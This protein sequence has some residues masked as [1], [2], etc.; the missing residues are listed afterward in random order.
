[1]HLL[2]GYHNKHKCG[3]TRRQTH[4][5]HLN[6]GSPETGGYGSYSSGGYSSLDSG[7]YG[8]YSSGSYGSLDSGSYGSYSSGSY[9]SLDSGSYGSAGSGGDG[10]YGSYGPDG[11]PV[12]FLLF[13]HASRARFV[14]VA[15]HT[16]QVFYCTMVQSK[17]H[18]NQIRTRHVSSKCHIVPHNTKEDI[19]GLQ[20]RHDLF[21]DCH[22][23]QPCMASQRRSAR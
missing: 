12:A 11:V 21:Q 19:P 5:G 20:I 9:G 17:M 2:H 4:L 18:Q 8:S 23:H 14:D 6:A 3:C 16:I 15:R 22:Q 10:S 13:F 7:S 1:M